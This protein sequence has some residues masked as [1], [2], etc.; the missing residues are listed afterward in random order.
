MG[1]LTAEMTPAGNG[2]AP[3]PAQGTY[4]QETPGQPAVVV[5]FENARHQEE[6]DGVLSAGAF[7]VLF[8]RHGA[9]PGVVIGG[10]FIPGE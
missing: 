2:G 6:G 1:S 3:V 9:Q 8:V 5:R 4:R 10:A 7:R